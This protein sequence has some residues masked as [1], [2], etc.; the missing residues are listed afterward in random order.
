MT[1]VHLKDAL[2]RLGITLCISPKTRSAAK[3]TSKY[4]SVVLR[5]FIRPDLIRYCL[6][7]ITGYRVVFPLTSL[8][9]LGVFPSDPHITL[10]LSPINSSMPA[11][12]SAR[13]GSVSLIARFPL[14]KVLLSTAVAGRLQCVRYSR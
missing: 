1:I 7:R 13:R 8:G 10:L 9:F 14:A 4:E 11:E 2:L 3:A 6:T 12:S 5:A